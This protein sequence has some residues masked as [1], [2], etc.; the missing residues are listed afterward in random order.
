[1]AITYSWSLVAREF[2]RSP[3]WS[4][5]TRAK[6]G[7]LA[8]FAI[9]LGATP[10]YVYWLLTGPGP[11]RRYGFS[12]VFVVNPVPSQR[13]AEIRAALAELSKTQTGKFCSVES[14]SPRH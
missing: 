8:G 3:R 12:S 14:A 6:V 9:S 11:W 13:P 2:A 4:P 10:P 5:Q 7:A 1:M